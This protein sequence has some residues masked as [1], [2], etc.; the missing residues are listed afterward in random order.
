MKQ[1][2]L[3]FSLIAGQIV[4]MPFAFAFPP[5]GSYQR[6]C[7]DIHREGRDLVATCKDTNGNWVNTKLSDYVGCKGSIDNVDGELQCDRK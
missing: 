3:A 7:K 1:T 6:S 4:F 5:S 2:I